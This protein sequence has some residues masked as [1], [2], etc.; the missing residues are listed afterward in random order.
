MDDLWIKQK[1][2]PYKFRLINLTIIDS[3]EWNVEMMER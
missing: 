3:A 1:F 2:K